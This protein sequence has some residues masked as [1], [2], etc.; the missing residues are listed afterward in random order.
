V[1]VMCVHPGVVKTNLGANAPARS[2][3]ERRANIKRQNITL[4]TAPRAA[5]KIL[6]GIERGK[7][8]VVIGADGKFMDLIGR[9]APARYPQLTFPVLR[10][11]EPLIGE[12]VSSCAADPG[13]AR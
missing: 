7:A 10:R 5:R 3:A 12:A 11:V 6:H 13:R 1:H 9:Y 8:R 4:T 2:E